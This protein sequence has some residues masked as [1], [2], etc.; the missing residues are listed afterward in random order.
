MA[1]NVLFVFPAAAM[2][3]TDLGSGAYNDTD[4]GVIAYRAVRLF[5]DESAHD[6]EILQLPPVRMPEA[7]EGG[8]LAL[9]LQ[10]CMVTGNVDDAV[11]LW[12]GC[13]AISDGATDVDTLLGD[14]QEDTIITV[15]DAAY[16]LDVVELTLTNDDSVAVGDLFRVTIRRQGVSKSDD[17]DGDFA[18]FCA[19][20]VEKG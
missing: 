6:S 2:E 4:T 12:T 17:A 15:P 8:T 19:T 18:L 9:I 13:E 3:N 10:Y 1:D 5:D 20:L 16:T 14:T 11:V 7:Y